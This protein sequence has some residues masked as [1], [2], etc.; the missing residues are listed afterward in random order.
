MSAPPTAGYCP[1]VPVPGTATTG[2]AP[3]VPL[4]DAVTGSGHGCALHLTVRRAQHART[5]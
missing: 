2:L 3:V 1:G 4:I 5:V